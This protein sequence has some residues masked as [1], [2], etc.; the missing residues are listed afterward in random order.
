MMNPQA[1][2]TQKSWTPGR[3]RISRNTIAQGVPVMR[4]NL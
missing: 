1:T 3:S 4:P 2:V